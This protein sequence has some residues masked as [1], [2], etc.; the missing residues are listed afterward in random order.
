MYTGKCAL[1]MYFKKHE[2]FRENNLR[3]DRLKTKDLSLFYGLLEVVY[4][5][6]LYIN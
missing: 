3:M 5:K 6:I 1:C 4:R 2:K